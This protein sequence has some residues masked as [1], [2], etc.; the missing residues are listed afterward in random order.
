MRKDLSKVNCRP[1]SGHVNDLRGQ[2]FG[3]LRVVEYYGVRQGAYWRCVCDCGNEVVTPSHDLVGGKTKSCG[4]LHIKQASELCKQRN[5]KHGYSKEP[6]YFVWKTMRQRCNNP[7]QHDYR[8]YGAKG[9]TICP[10]WDDYM[11]FREWALSHGYDGK[12]T[13]DRIDFNKGYSP[14]NCRFITIQEQQQN[15]SNVKKVL[16]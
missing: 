16:Q 6:L 1:M 14:D 2:R 15:K 12:L 3:M 4:C 7:N 13:I 9:V 10:E 5:T 8:W 11:A